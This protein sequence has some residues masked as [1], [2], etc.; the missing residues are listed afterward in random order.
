M[1]GSGGLRLEL[2]GD[3]REQQREGAK[4]RAEGFLSAQADRLT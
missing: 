2:G 4:A 1:T 3:A